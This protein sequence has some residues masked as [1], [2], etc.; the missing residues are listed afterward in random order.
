MGS[1]SE[2]SG[3]GSEKK[4]RCAVVRGRESICTKLYLSGVCADVLLAQKKKTALSCIVSPACGFSGAS[5][6]TLNSVC[7][8]GIASAT[9]RRTGMSTQNHLQATHTPAKPRHSQRRHHRESDLKKTD[10]AY[11][12]RTGANSS[13]R[14][15]FPSKLRTR[16]ELNPKIPS[17]QSTWR[18]STAKE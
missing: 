1:L 14:S 4:K 16:F 8:S 12:C 18:R 11:R 3:R 7:T 2:T 10:S 6:V 9:G 17:C 15:C 5:N 13:S